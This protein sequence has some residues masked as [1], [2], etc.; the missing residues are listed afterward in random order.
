VRIEDVREDR[1]VEGDCI[2][3]VGVV[4]RHHGFD[5]LRSCKRSHFGWPV[6]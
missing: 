3:E 1:A 2:V 4:A 6:D 5:F